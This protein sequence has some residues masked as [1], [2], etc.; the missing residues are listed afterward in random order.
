MKLLLSPSPCVEIHAR[1]SN[2]LLHWQT[3]LS[4]GL[5]RLFFT[6]PNDYCDYD[7][8]LRR[9]LCSLFVLAADLNTHLRPEWLESPA[10]PGFR[11]SETSRGA[12]GSAGRTVPGAVAESDIF[13]L[14]APSGLSLP[15]T[16]GRV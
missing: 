2:T 4:K 12:P 11:W 16:G 9:W 3:S 7:L 8:G 13:S 5:K 15:L 1:T 10:H 6:H 14:P